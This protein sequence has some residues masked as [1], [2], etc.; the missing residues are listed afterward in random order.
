VTDKQQLYRHAQEYM[1]RGW[2][3]FPVGGVDG[4]RPLVKWGDIVATLDEQVREWLQV[5][6]VTGWGLPTGSRSGIV[7]VD[8]DG[9]EAPSWA[10]P[11][12]TV[13][14]PRGFHLYYATDE[15]IKN[16]VKALA[17]NVDVRGEG[18]FVVLPG[19]RRPDGTEYVEAGGE[20]APLPAEVVEAGRATAPSLIVLREPEPSSAEVWHRA[21]AYARRC[22]PSISGSGGHAQALRVARAMVHGFQ[23]PEGEALAAM[24]AWNASCQPPW[25]ERELAHKVRSAAT[26]A[27]PASRPAGYLL[28]ERGEELVLID[29]TEPPARKRALPTPDI[30]EDAVRE[31]LARKVEDIG[32][33]GR[34]YMQWLRRSSRIWQPGLAVGSALALGA[35]LAGRR[36][37]WRGTTSHLY[38]LGIGGSGTGKDIA[39]KRLGSILGEQVMG[40]IPSTKALRDRLLEASQRG[41]GLCLVSGEVAKLLRQILGARTPAY[42]QLAGQMLLECATWG[43]EPMRI[44]RAASDQGGDGNQIVID[45]PSLSIYGTATPEDLLDILGEG[46]VKDGM[47]GRFIVMRAQEKLPDKNV[48]LEP[49]GMPVALAMVLADRAREIDNWI[50]RAEN[51]LWAPPPEP[52]PGT[53]G[54][55]LAAYDEKIHRARQIAYGRP[56]AS[57]PDELIARLAEHAARVAIALAGLSSSPLLTSDCERLA[58]A[59]TEQSARDVACTVKRHAARDS[60]ERGLKRVLAACER[61]QGPDGLVRSCDL[62]QAVRAA[63]LPKWIDALLTEG[64]LRRVEVKARGREATRYRLA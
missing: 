39:A 20:M 59:I 55:V 45:A 8:I 64:S 6:P 26:T 15:R 42:L 25:S 51:D 48:Y 21:E 36:Y 34:M 33:I 27:D 12:Y 10:T 43:M 5:L 11:T 24:A 62:A 41:R 35:T 54:E 40:G 52:M 53:K 13:T 17:D 61:L 44:D 2:P 7:V 19:S 22:E 46:S 37:H 30:D 1:R 14:T 23:L 63:D 32:D 57:M 9:G 38:V 56:D 49:E 18:G 16:S 3:I 4:K 60:W 28:D 50:S 47:L 58:I 29:D 31:D